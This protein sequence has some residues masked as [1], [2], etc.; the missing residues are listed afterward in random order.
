[1]AKWLFGVD[2]ADDIRTKN[3]FGHTPMLAAFGDHL[4]V[5]KWRFAVAAA[6]DTRKVTRASFACLHHHHHHVA[7]WLILKG[8]TNNDE[9]TLTRGQVLPLNNSLPRAW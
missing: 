2:A 8:A 7:M 6:E 1:M 5:A 9:P 3:C 4:Q